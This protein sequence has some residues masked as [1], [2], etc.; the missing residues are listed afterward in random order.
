MLHHYFPCKQAGSLFYPFQIGSVEDVECVANSCQ[1][2][3]IVTTH[4]LNWSPAGMC[5]RSGATA[6]VGFPNT[7]ACSIC[8]KA[9]HCSR[10]TMGQVTFTSNPFPCPTKTSSC[11]LYHSCPNRL[12]DITCLLAWNQP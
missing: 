1:Q 9:P 5:Q 2:L 4:H 7:A 10:T 8:K 6:M 3:P 11:P 12:F